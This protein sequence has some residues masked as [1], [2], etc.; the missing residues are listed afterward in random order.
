MI[1][2]IPGSVA[3][4]EWIVRG[5]HHDAWVNGAE[6]PVCGQVALL[7]EA[8][9]LGALLKQG[10]KPR[11]TIIYCAWDG[12]EPML[13]GSTEWAETHA[14]E[15]RRMPPST[16]TPTATIAGCLTMGGSHS[17][18]QFINGVA[19]DIEDPETKMTVWKRAQL[20]QIADAKTAEERQEVRQRADLRIDALGSGTD[21]TAFLDHLGIAIAEFGIWRR[22]RTGDLS[23]DLRR[24]LLVHAFF[25]H[26]FR[27]RP[28]AGADGGNVG[29]AAGGCGSAAV[30]L[31]GFCR[32]GG[33]V[34]ERTCRSCC[35]RSR[36]KFASGIRNW[37]K[38]YS[39]RRSIRGG[40]RWLR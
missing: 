37:R 11:R 9:A 27:L 40:R 13:L 30:R 28:G 24:F 33:H 29:D 34:Q 25:G 36:T 26:G 2:K 18:E 35:R 31:R 8:R 12:E 6:D 17:L 7:E 10:W 20:T 21:F 4:D 1:A 15:L 23:L 16:S 14:D 3:P 39:R 22:G 32:H 38:E 19:R 5:N